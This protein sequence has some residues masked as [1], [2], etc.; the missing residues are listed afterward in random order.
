LLIFSQV[1][2]TYAQELS[3]G[4]AKKV[5]V[6][7]MSAF[8]GAIVCTKSGGF[9]LCNIEYSPSM[10]GV[11]SD[12]PAAYFDIAPVENGRLVLSDGVVK[13]KITNSNGSI[14]K[15]DFVTSSLTPGIAQKA[16]ENGYVLGMAL[17]DA[18]TQS[19]GDINVSIAINIHPEAQLSNTRSNLV[20]VLRDASKAPI[21]E[22]L[23]SFRYLLAA[24]LVVISFTLG[25][26]Y[27]GRM[28]NTGVEAIGRNPLAEKQ[29]RI[30]VILHVIVTLLIIGV[31]L[32]TAYLVLLL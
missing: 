15:G 12:N 21:L 6:I 26:V 32:F 2:I 16:T 25:F 23:A 11:V 24:I 3:T 13:V 19:N 20:A 18:V 27:F 30:N 28:A 17:A 22:P 5:S 14:R 4:I 29:I 8:D 31:G 1:A 10:F 7:E 9:G